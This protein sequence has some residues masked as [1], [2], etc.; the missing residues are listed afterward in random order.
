MS[1]KK[2]GE[3]DVEKNK[4]SKS[5]GSRSS[6]TAATTSKT[7]GGFTKAQLKT[8]NSLKKS[9]TDLQKK[10]DKTLEGHQ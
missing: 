5:S 8:L 1:K 7:A 3:K 4:K 2:T 9:V 6:S 10:L